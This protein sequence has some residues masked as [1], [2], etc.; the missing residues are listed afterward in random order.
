VAP[1]DGAPPLLADLLD[2]FGDDIRYCL[3]RDGHSLA[4]LA[5]GGEIDVLV[6]PDDRKQLE[7]RL[8]DAGFVRLPAWGHA[9]HRFFV[10]YDRASDAWFKVDVVDRIAY[11]RPVHAL[12][13]SLGEPCI[14]RR[15]R[16]GVAF[17]PA[18]EDELVTLLLHCLLDTGAF[19]DRKRTRLRELC[20]AV[21]DETAVNELLAELG[22]R[23]LTWSRISRSIRDEEWSI[24]MSERTVAARDLRKRDRA[25]TVTRWLR[26]RAA[27]KIANVMRVLRPQA[28]T[29]ALLAPD[30]A[31]K[32]TLAE[33]VRDRLFFPVRSVYMGLYQ[34]NSGPAGNSPVPGLGFVVRLVR[35]WIR[36]TRA[37]WHTAQGRFVIFDRYSYDAL[38]ATPRRQSRLG[39]FRRG[40]LAHS[41]PA[42]D[43]VFILDAP[44]EVLY[45]RKGE[46]TP[47]A[48][49]RQ[50]QQY[51]ELAGLLP[52]A[53]IVDANQDPE[54]V[55]RDVTDRIWRRFA[56]GRG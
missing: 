56:D 55:R 1:T 8:A 12:A 26:D 43:L 24:L 19:S 10:A 25:G 7:G 4:D 38:L 22:V 9:P 5:R 51:R 42:P 2:R 6:S 40:L 29:V 28:L 33:S 30:G 20:N 37:R 48:L 11:G 32:S 49:E 17:V 39:R 23:G 52:R 35:Q 3:L 41:C 21:E 13:T 50:R 47:D 54:Q 16:A 53:V 46:H 27:R 45:G 15:R 44:G 18:P 31:G 36:W 14:R 34:K